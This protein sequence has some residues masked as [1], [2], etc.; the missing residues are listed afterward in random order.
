MPNYSGLKAEIAKP[1][2]AGMTDEQIAEAIVEPHPVDIDVQVVD[3]EAYLRLNGLMFKLAR[4]SQSP[5]AGADPVAVVLA[6]ELYGLITAPRTITL[7]TSDSALKAQLQGQLSLLQAAGVLSAQ[8]VSDLTA[9]MTGSESIAQ[10]LGFPPE[11]DMTQE[12][13]AARIHG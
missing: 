12:I 4:F 8:N 6:F 10:R 2:Y 7:H 3:V 9:K 13:A 11:A 5:P 1:D